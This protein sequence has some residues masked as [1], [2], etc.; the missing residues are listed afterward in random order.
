VRASESTDPRDKA[1]A[2]LGLLKNDFQLC[3]VDYRKSVSQVYVEATAGILKHT[4][5]LHFLSWTHNATGRGGYSRP[6]ELPSWT[7]SWTSSEKL[8]SSCSRLM[9]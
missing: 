2:M 6:A 7:P 3:G 5:S 1:F 8:F 9:K 4:E